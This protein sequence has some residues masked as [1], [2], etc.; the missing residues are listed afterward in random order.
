MVVTFGC[1]LHEIGTLCEAAGITGVEWLKKYTDDTDILDCIRYDKTPDAA[2]DSAAHIVR[3]ANRIAGGADGQVKHKGSPLLGSIFN[4][5]NGHTNEK[6]LLPKP[7]DKQP[8]VYVAD[9]GDDASVK[10]LYSDALDKLARGLGTIKF[11]EGY[12][13]PLISLLEDLLSFFPSGISDEPAADVSLY[14]HIKMTAAVGAS[15]IE[16]LRERGIFD[17]KSCDSPFMDEPAFL[18][19]SCDFSGIQSFLYNIVS[20]RALKS[21]RSRSFTLQLLMEYTVDE[22]LTGCEL[23]RANLIYS[24][25]GHCYLLLPNTEKV[26][27]CV[28]SY[29]AAMRK[30]LINQFGSAL[31]MAVAWR[32]CSANDLLNQPSEN[33]PYQAIFRDLTD[34]LS[35]RKLCRYTPDEMRVLNSAKHRD[36]ARECNICGMTGSLNPENYCE[37]CENFIDISPRLLKDDLYIAVSTDRIF[38]QPHISFP[39]LTGE[40]YLY[41][42]DKSSFNALSGSYSIRRVYLKNT[43]SP[44]IRNSIRIFIGDYCYAPL[45]EELTKDEAGINRIGVLRADVDNL[46]YAFTRGFERADDEPDGKFKYVNLV[47]SASFSRHMSLFY[48]YYINTVLAKADK[49]TEDGW[50][51]VL[52]YSGGDDLFLIGYW[53]DVIGAAIDIVAAFNEYAAGTLTL[54]GG[55]GIFPV[56]YPVLKEAE[57]TKALEDAS[58]LNPDKNAVTLFSP[59]AGNTYRWDVFTDKVI[60]QK[61]AALTNFFEAGTASKDRNPEQERGNA[62][63]YRLLTLLRESRDEP[64]NSQE[65]SE[66]VKAEKQRGKQQRKINIARYAYLLARME[67]PKSQPAVRQAYLKFS[68]DMYRWITKPTDRD[69]LITAIQIYIYKTRKRNERE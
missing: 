36:D 54:S 48:Q 15:I 63:L 19:V 66:D 60:G 9:H 23:S 21:L 14:D 69:E 29:A 42:I 3:M 13:N 11:E 51:V 56:K 33:A 37:W 65:Q 12:I 57:E 6:Y 30:W 10:A 20:D 59:E 40:A 53:R 64:V 58:K 4:R 1:L 16:Y 18:M 31:Y 34:R 45:L 43:V 27:E 47:R 39:T 38:R 25:G 50:Q 49:D 68:R 61:L 52:V 7:L 41:F 44:G 5:L 55:I 2:A 32:P 28:K 26:I 24:G 62:F 46:G 17:Y 22:I 67:P 35:A 8:P